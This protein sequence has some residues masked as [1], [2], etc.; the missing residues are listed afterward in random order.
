MSFVAI[1]TGIKSITDFQKHL[2]V[3]K[4]KHFTNPCKLSILITF[5]DMPLQK[6]KP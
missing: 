2:D 1:K 5:C 6:K 3:D 4:K